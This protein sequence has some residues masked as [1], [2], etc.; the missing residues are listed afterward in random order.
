MTFPVIWSA[1]WLLAVLLFLLIVTPLG[2][3]QRLFS[4]PLQLRQGL[5]CATCWQQWPR[6]DDMTSYLRQY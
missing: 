4:D 2:L 1:W 3:L 6:T 5:R